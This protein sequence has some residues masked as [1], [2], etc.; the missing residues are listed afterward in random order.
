AARAEFVAGHIEAS[1]AHCQMAARLAE[2]A[3]RP[4][5]LA[6]AALVI[7]G[8]G[9]PATTPAVDALCGKAIRAVPAQDTALRARLR[10]RQAIA[11]A[12][13]ARDHGGGGLPAEALA[14]ANPRDAPAALRDAPP[15]GP[16]PWGAPNSRPKGGGPGAGASRAPP[17]P[18]QPL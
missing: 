4:D 11:A 10:A 13:P 17:G 6:A 9:D 3:G 14:P 18:R 5:I 1:L 7:T 2:D 15:A 12:N 8:V 16:L